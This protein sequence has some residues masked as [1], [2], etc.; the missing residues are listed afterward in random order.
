MPSGGI[1]MWPKPIAPTA[2]YLHKV[3]GWETRKTLKLA[4]TPDRLEKN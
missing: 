3:G 4:T 1:G 2:V